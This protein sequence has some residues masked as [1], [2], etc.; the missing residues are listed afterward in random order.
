MLN[1]ELRITEQLIT[2]NWLNG[3]QATDRIYDSAWEAERRGCEKCGAVGG[4]LSLFFHWA[5]TAGR[6]LPKHRQCELRPTTETRRCPLAQPRQTASI[7]SDCPSPTRA[8]AWSQCFTQWVL[9]QGESHQLRRGNRSTKRQHHP[10]EGLYH[11]RNRPKRHPWRVVCRDGSSRRKA[12]VVG[13][14]ESHHR[15]PVKGNRSRKATFRNREDASKE[16]FTQRVDRQIHTRK[17][18]HFQAQGGVL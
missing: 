17:P 13:R 9:I 11:P 15:Q 6:C 3:Q 16:A 18:K 5:N 12:E 8:W 10:R 2:D 14:V 4:K 1:E 7:H